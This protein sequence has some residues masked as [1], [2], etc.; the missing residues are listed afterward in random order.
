MRRAH[1]ARKPGKRRRATRRSAGAT[2]LAREVSAK[3]FNM[4]EFAMELARRVETF[5]MPDRTAWVA[6]GSKSLRARVDPLGAQLS[7]LADADGRPLLWSGDPTVWSGRAPLL[8]PIVGALA[9][10]RYRRGSRH[11]ALPRHGFARTTLFEQIETTPVSATFRLRSDENTRQV[12]PFRFE[13]Q[14]HFEIVDATLSVLSLVHNAGDEDMAASFGY[15]PAFRWPLPYGQPRE[16][17]FVEFE[18][19]EL[20]PIR[21]LNAD[22]LLTAARL[23]TPVSGRRLMLDDALFREDAVI[24]DELASRSV[25]YGAAG[26]PR[27]QVR[28][29]DTPYFGLWTKPRRAGFICLEPW[30]GIADPEGFS[31]DFLEKPGVFII[32]VGAAMPMKMTIELLAA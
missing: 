18:T 21:R 10:G 12:Y 7:E 3:G 23:A 24:F 25:T 31:G 22:G 15:H 17:H 19:D 1:R 13:L 28:F 20:A 2:T 14:V 29:P 11:Y 30:H 9:G 4:P 8:F 6:F 27:L 5:N 32:P 26:A 16:A